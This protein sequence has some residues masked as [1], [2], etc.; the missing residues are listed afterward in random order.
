MILVFAPDPSQQA[1]LDALLQLQQDPGSPLF[2]QWVTPREFGDS[3]GVSDGD[4]N[5]LIQ[6]LHGQGFQ[7]EPVPPSRRALIFSGMAAQVQSAFH[8]QIHVY[9]VEGKQHYAN[10]TDPEI[11]EALA[12]VVLGVGPLHDFPPRAQYHRVQQ[13]L[14]DLTSSDGSA[15][16]L[17]PADLAAIY[18]VS[19]LC[20]YGIDGRGQSIAIVGRTN[21]D[22]SNVRKFRQTFGLP[23]NDPIVTVNGDDPGIVSDEEAGE[24]YLDV[25]WVARLPP[26]LRSSSLSPVLPTESSSRQI[27]LFRIILRRF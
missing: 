12:E 9:E 11:A 7:T 17:A 25:E 6:W 14:P 3:F 26:I 16:A 13:P 10:A 8:T 5:Q 27:M 4:L 20:W 23:A 22:I 18:N 19:P 2:H 21:I 24:A 1:S 15:H